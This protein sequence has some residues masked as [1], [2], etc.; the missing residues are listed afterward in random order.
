MQCNRGVERAGPRFRCGG[1]EGQVGGIDLRVLGSVEKP[2]VYPVAPQP[3]LPVNV[4]RR[5]SSDCDAARRLGRRL[6]GA[7][8]DVS[9]CLNRL[10]K[11]NLH[12]RRLIL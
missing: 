4:P 12:F 9:G 3:H 6:V 1:L 11:T 10:I 7:A 2:G 8:H 5:P